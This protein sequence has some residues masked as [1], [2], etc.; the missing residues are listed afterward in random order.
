MDSIL[1][2]TMCLPPIPVMSAIVRHSTLLVEAHE[3]YQ[4]RSF[5]NRIHLNGPQG[6]VSFSIP[7]RSGKNSQMPIQDVRISY[8]TPWHQ[9]LMKRISTNYGSAPFFE[10]LSDDLYRI[11]DQQ[12]DFL[13][14]LNLALL[15]WINDELS[16]PV[17]I[18]LSETYNKDYKD[19]IADKRN[20]YQLKN[21]SQSGIQSSPY[22]QVFSHEHG[23]VRDLSIL[24]MLMSCG[25]ESILKLKDIN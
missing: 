19:S 10:H 13:W 5:R 25:P 4:K 20:Q 22:E 14:D 11:L 16:Q 8:E 24:D 12:W 17:A 21:I 2:E 6:K 3:H 15:N 9:I 7:L 18:K 23:F 1:I